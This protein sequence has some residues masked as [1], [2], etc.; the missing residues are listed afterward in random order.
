[1]SIVNWGGT[2]AKKALEDIETSPEV[3]MLLLKKTPQQLKDRWKG[4]LMVPEIDGPRGIK[5]RTIMVQ[6]RH[7][8]VGDVLIK[9]FDR[10]TRDGNKLVHIT[11]NEAAMLS[12]DDIAEMNMAIKEGIKVYRH[13][14]AW[15]QLNKELGNTETIF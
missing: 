3:S 10:P 5:A 1:M 13:P 2:K 12:E 14:A 4:K 11:M 9:I 8:F 6:L 7:K 15:I